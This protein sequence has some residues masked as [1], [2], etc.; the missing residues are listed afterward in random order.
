MRITDRGVAVLVEAEAKLRQLLTDAATAGDYDAIQ[1]ITEWARAVQAL[2]AKG[3]QGFDIPE[4]ES[5]TK[6]KRTSAGPYPR[7][8]R[9]GDQLVKTGWSKQER[10]EY[11]HSAPE[12]A[13]HSLAAAVTKQSRNGRIFTAKNLFPLRDPSDDSELPTY[14]AYVA[15]AWLKQVRLVQQRGRSGY[16]AK[17][18]V[19]FPAAVAKAWRDL[20]ELQAEV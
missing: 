2:H 9:R 1:R 13:I 3:Q 16:S 8:A 14:K 17:K 10:R 11:E 12:H 7:F 18:S 20:P 4:E 6:A 5:P 15:L 19:D